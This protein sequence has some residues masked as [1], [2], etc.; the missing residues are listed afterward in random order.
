MQDANHA[1]PCLA[2]LCELTAPQLLLELCSLEQSF[3]LN[4]PNLK[5]FPPT[6]PRTTHMHVA[7]AVLSFTLAVTILV[8]CGP[9][10]RPEVS[11]LDSTP[12]SANVGLLDEINRAQAWFLAKK[13]RPIWAKKVQQD[14]TVKTLEGEE[15]IRA[16]DYLC[17]GEAGDVWPQKAESLEAKYKPTDTI[18]D[19]G[20]RKYEPDPDDQGVLAAQVAHPFAVQATWGRLS[21][22]A[23]DYV[24]K[25]F[26]DKNTD[27]PQDV[28]IVD[29]DLFHAT[30]ERVQP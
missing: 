21:G 3:L 28:W 16:G 5:R 10:Q 18:D 2:R 24:V 9:T 6:D 11:V 20:W 26:D 13:T 19:D 8:G 25:N 23:G 14:Q 7:R 12:D 15:S 29:Q 4:R 1:Q 30:Y 27:Y 17:R 22:K